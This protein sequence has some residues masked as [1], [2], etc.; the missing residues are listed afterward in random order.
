MKWEIDEECELELLLTKHAWGKRDLV[1]KVLKPYSGEMADDIAPFIP[2]GKYTAVA[3]Y[4]FHKRF[5][6]PYRLV[7][8]TISSLT[9]NQLAKEI[10]EDALTTR[11]HESVA[12]HK[13]HQS[14][15]RGVE[16]LDSLRIAGTLG[17]EEYWFQMKG[18]SRVSTIRHPSPWQW[19][20]T[21]KPRYQESFSF[22]NEVVGRGK[23][24]L[25]LLGIIE[26]FD[27]IE[28]FQLSF[29]VLDGKSGRDYSKMWFTKFI[30]IS[31][32][33]NILTVNRNDA[34]LAE[35]QIYKGTRETLN[36]VITSCSLQGT[37]IKEKIRELERA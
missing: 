25:P 32:R 10:L 21:Y 4:L 37:D 30:N 24:I 7:R 23:L 8:T 29:S 27:E 14:G 1:M 6:S 5:Y 33:M 15:Y 20:V 12:P 17:G 28:E 3:E 2:E 11:D 22:V 35:S 13:G 34:F 36:D 31:Y 18:K 9:T 26:A 19:K 16:L